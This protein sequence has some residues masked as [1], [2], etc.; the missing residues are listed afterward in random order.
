MRFRRSDPMFDGLNER[1]AERLRAFL[2]YDPHP[3]QGARVE[4]NVGPDT[5]I[6]PCRLPDAAKQGGRKVKRA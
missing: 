2:R 3:G 5:E 1:D 6:V 4:R